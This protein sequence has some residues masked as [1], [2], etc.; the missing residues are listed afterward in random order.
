MWLTLCCQLRVMSFHIAAD[1]SWK[2]WV[3]LRILLYYRTWFQ[4]V[5]KFPLLNEN[6][7]R[8]Q[9]LLVS[10]QVNTTGQNCKKKMLKKWVGVPWV[11]LF[12][13][14]KENTKLP[15]VRLHA[16]SLTPLERA[17][18]EACGREKL[19]LHNLAI[20][21]IQAGRRFTGSGTVQDLQS[22]V[23]T[24][25]GNTTNLDHHLSHR[26]KELHKEFEASQSRAQTLSSIK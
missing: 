16:T 10:I 5:R 13:W 9:F 19:H 24:S 26:H 23:A 14:I 4:C 17:L 8:F 18:S 20:L 3:T 6:F 25:R 12:L 7:I 22:V 11:L 21:W 2:F 1:R 15:W